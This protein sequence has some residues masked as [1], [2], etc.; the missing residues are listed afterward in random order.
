METAGNLGHRAKSNL[1]RLWN[2]GLHYVGT[3]NLGKLREKVN[4]V[5]EL[6][7]TQPEVPEQVVVDQKHQ[8]A[9]KELKNMWSRG[10]SLTY[11]YE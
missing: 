4:A 7:R 6:L 2:S 5:Y 9:P 11:A 10:P 3:Q 8:D 1:A